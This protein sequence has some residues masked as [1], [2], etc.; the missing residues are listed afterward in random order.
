MYVKCPSSRLHFGREAT[1]FACIL[2][3]CVYL[4]EWKLS[5]ILFTRIQQPDQVP[6]AEAVQR[7]SVQCQQ[8]PLADL[9][10]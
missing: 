3:K 5:S 9:Q 1:S 6:E 7:T 8:K 2:R 10:F 4:S